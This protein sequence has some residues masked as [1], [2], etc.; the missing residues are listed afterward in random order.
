M[1]TLTRTATDSRWRALVVVAVAQ[2]MVAL[3]ATS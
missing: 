2:L 3:D 1:S